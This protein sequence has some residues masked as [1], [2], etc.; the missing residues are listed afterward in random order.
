MEPK[1]GR[2]SKAK[3]VYVVLREKYD[4]DMG[5]LQSRI[6]G[7]EALVQSQAEFIEGLRTKMAAKTAPASVPNPQ[8]KA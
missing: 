5:V 7:L 3:P 1:E 2:I 6:A 4:A 8:P